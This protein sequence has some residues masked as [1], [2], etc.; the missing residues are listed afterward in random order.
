[1]TDSSSLL[2][3]L[4]FADEEVSREDG[5]EDEDDE[6]EDDVEAGEGGDEEVPG[7]DGGDS[8]DDDN[9][10]DVECV[11]VEATCDVSVCIP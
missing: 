10:D 6:G 11:S 5:H 4:E 1:M 2:V 3:V 9:I 8:A 7:D